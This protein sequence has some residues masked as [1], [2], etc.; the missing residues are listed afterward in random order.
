MGSKH[1]C[2]SWSIYIH[3]CALRHTHPHTHSHMT[4]IALFSAVG[5]LQQ[6]L[7][8]FHNIVYLFLRLRFFFPFFQGHTARGKAWEGFWWRGWVFRHRQYFPHLLCLNASLL[9]RLNHMCGVL[10]WINN[11]HFGGLAGTWWPHA[12][13]SLMSSTGTAPPW[14]WRV[15]QR[16]RPCPRPSPQ[17]HSVW[18][19]IT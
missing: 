15:S 14:H 17:S 18:A 6:W 4:C 2:T 12:D 7:L 9:A 1:A 8:M 13:G 3:K 16:T 10:S 11:G 5:K 19:L